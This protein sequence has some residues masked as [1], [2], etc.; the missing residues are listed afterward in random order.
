[1]L[2]LLLCTS[3]FAAEPGGTLR[4][5]L[6]RK[7][8][9]VGMLPGLVPFVAAGADADELKRLLGADAPS[10]ARAVDGRAVCGFDVELAQ[11]TA[12]AL[13]VAVELTLV[14]T[15]DDLLAG[16][17]DGRFDVVMSAVTRT[18]ERATTVAFSD[19]YFASGLL[20]L[21]RDPARFPTVETLRKPELKVAFRAGTTA[22]GFAAREL[23]GARLVPLQ[24]DAALYAAMDDP[25]AA[26]AVVVDYVSAR[27]AEVRG[28]VKS[29]LKPVEE[30]R[31]TTEHFAF[32]AR[33]G[34]P[35][36]VAWLNLFLRDAKTSGAFHR[37]AARYNRW[38]RAER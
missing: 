1:A 28:R 24:S 34:D 11:E 3:S 25:A 6:H 30:R 20:V 12:R 9:R 19:P 35:D 29:L 33:Q 36:W 16:V 15:F 37:L 17:R 18:L 7:T 22:Q 26:D 5:V 8:L 10:P 27:D 38:F 14:D 31:F 21:V 4:T 23:A 2:V 32:V 13:G